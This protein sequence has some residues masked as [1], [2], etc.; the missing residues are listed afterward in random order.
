MIRPSAFRLSPA[1]RP[2]SRRRLIALTGQWDINTSHRTNNAG[3][4]RH[5]VKPADPHALVEAVAG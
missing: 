1:D 2:G 5:L 3:F 4:E